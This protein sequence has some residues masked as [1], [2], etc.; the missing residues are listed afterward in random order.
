MIAGT[1]GA[2]GFGLGLLLSGRWSEAERRAI[3]RTL[4][5]VGL[6]STIPLAA[7]VLSRLGPASREQNMRELQS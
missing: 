2:L 3:G 6:L 5:L 7:D 4:V 1:R